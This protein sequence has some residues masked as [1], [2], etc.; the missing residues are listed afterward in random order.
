MSQHWSHSCGFA[1]LEAVTSR[2]GKF[3][4]LSVWTRFTAAEAPSP[5]FNQSRAPPTGGLCAQALRALIS[6][7]GRRANCRPPA[8]HSA[9]TAC[10]GPLFMLALRFKDPHLIFICSLL[11]GK[12]LP[13]SLSLSTSLFPR[14]KAAAFLLTCSSASGGIRPE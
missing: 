10:A 14:L 3:F 2:Q 8:L 6:A 9:A 12:E 5:P 13:S 7:G 4:S 1:D 11:G